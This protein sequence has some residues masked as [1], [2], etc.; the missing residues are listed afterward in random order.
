[1]INYWW[2]QLPNK[3]PNIELAEFINMPKHL[4][5]IIT[6]RADQ[7]VSP[8][9]ENGLQIG[10]HVTG[11]EHTGS[12]LRN[13][14][15]LTQLIQWFKTMTTNED[16]RYIKHNK[17]PRFI[18]RLWQRNFYEHIVRSENE[19]NRIGTFI[20]VNPLNWKVDSGN[21]VR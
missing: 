15:G 16:I 21:P 17:W 5:G 8:D 18:N 3:Y 14:V 10:S 4:H 7:C 6:V 2:H 20:I 12:P 11:G 19:M 1:M 9:N 13:S